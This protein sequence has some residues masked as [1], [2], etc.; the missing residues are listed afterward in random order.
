[1]FNK[2]AK[3]EETVCIHTIAFTYSRCISTKIEKYHENKECTGIDM[4]LLK[5]PNK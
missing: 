3:G 5:I 1:M 4:R 2:Y